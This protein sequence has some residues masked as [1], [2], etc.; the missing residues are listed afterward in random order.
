MSSIVGKVLGRLICMYVCM[1]VNIYIYIYKWLTWE[2][3]LAAIFQTRFSYVSG[4][5]SNANTRLFRRKKK[6]QTAAKKDVKRAP[7]RHYKSIYIILYICYCYMY[8]YRMPP[9]QIVYGTGSIIS[10]YT[11]FW[12][13]CGAVS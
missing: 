13:P 2:R 1:Y 10:I 11:H 9:P 6:R 7:Q 3:L 4:T 8:K 12:S 5:G